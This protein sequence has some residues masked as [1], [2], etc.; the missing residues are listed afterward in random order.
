MGCPS[1]QI[2][3][4]D[5]NGAERKMDE[6]LLAKIS[7]CIAKA[8][9]D[10]DTSGLEAELNKLVPDN[11][12]HDDRADILN[13]AIIYTLVAEQPGYD[14]DGL[15]GVIPSNADLK[16]AVL[17]EIDAMIEADFDKSEHREK[18]Q[19]I[20]KSVR[21]TPASDFSPGVAVNCPD[22]YLLMLDRHTCAEF[23]KKY[24]LLPSWASLQGNGN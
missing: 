4:K 11:L 5:S 2:I 22:D 7:Q 24:N 14:P 15:P 18:W 1:S 9:N 16:G 10:G 8:F 20:E 12:S 6:D 21:N 23:L 3:L 17:H 19:E 13:K